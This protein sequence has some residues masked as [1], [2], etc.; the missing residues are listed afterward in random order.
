M[1][2]T[3]LKIL[4]NSKTPQQQLFLIIKINKSS[5]KVFFVAKFQNRRTKWKKQEQ[6]G[7]TPK[8]ETATTSSFMALDDR[9]QSPLDYSTPNHSHL[10][11]R[12][13]RNRD[14]VSTDESDEKDDDEMIDNMNKTI[15]VIVADPFIAVYSIRYTLLFVVVTHCRVAFQIFANLK[16]SRSIKQYW[17]EYSIFRTSKKDNKPSDFVYRPGLGSVVDPAPT[18][19]F[20]GLTSTNERPKVARLNIIL[21]LGI[22]FDVQ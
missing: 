9:G 7:K 12:F 16:I 18:P 21:F 10:A 19:W 15:S 13:Y 5:N 6:D 14:N 11:Q 20:S 2:K 22:P 17:F 1:M 4:K 8:T 3:M